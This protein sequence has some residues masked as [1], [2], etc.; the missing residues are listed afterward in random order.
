MGGESI[1]MQVEVVTMS[2]RAMAP[3]TLIIILEMTTMT[4]VTTRHRFPCFGE[5]GATRV[6]PT[7]TSHDLRDCRAKL[8]VDATI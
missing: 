8:Y 1:Y 7:L 5:R 6:P 4:M 3:P 2:H